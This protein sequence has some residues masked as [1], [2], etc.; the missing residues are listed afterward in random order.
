MSKLGS[1]R[2]IIVYLTSFHAITLQQSKPLSKLNNEHV[3]LEF[4]SPIQE[5]SNRQFTTEKDLEFRKLKRKS[6]LCQLSLR[7]LYRGKCHV[8]PPIT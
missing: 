2:M 3:N 7:C 8:W 1:R 6:N 5:Y 4:R